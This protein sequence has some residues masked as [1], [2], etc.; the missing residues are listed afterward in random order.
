MEQTEAQAIEAL[1]DRL[2]F[3]DRET[4]ILR[5]RYAG[6]RPEPL[7]ALAASF[8][9]SRQRVH[10]IEGALLQRLR[11]AWEVTRAFIELPPTLDAA[12]F[13][14]IHP[15][16]QFFR[17]RRMA[18]LRRCDICEEPTRTASPFCRE[19]RVVQLQCTHCTKTFTRRRVVHARRM[20]DTRYGGPTFCSRQCLGSHLGTTVGFGSPDHPYSKK[21][22]TA[23]EQPRLDEVPPLT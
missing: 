19:H 22:N 5:Q 7:S 9:C 21:H 15:R 3:N 10:Q 13:A 18:A 23:R 1:L 14:N 8:G 2:T 20:R 4:A 11:T 16:N 6:T 17:E 12:V